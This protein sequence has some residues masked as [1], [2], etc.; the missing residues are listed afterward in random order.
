MDTNR[1]VV[2]TDPAREDVRFLE[3]RLYEY[4]VAQTGLDDGKWLAIFIRDAKQV[5]QAGIEGWTWCGS[6]FIRSLWVHV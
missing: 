6:C 3:D 2:E 5:I 1:L 4:N